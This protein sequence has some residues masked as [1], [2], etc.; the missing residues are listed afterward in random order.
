MSASVLNLLSGQ[1]L[2]SSSNNSQQNQSVDGPNLN[3]AGNSI[4]LDSSF[5]NGQNARTLSQFARQFSL[6]LSQQR[7]QF[8][9]PQSTEVGNDLPQFKKPIDVNEI[10][11]VVLEEMIERF[12]PELGNLMTSE[13]ASVNFSQNTQLSD[14]QIS[15]LQQQLQGLSATEVTEEA[16]PSLELSNIAAIIGK[17]DEQ[18]DSIMRRAGLIETDK[19]L[20]VD[21]QTNEPAVNTN[22]LL[23]D[24]KPQS[25]P[26]GLVEVI[27]PKP[28][29]NFDKPQLDVQTKP[30]PVANIERLPFEWVNNQLAVNSKTNEALD[31]ALKQVGFSEKEIAAIKIGELGLLLNK[32]SKLDL[33]AE[34]LSALKEVISIAKENLSKT[35]TA[36]NLQGVMGSVNI[37]QPKAIQSLFLPDNG[38][39]SRLEPGEPLYQPPSSA[40][41]NEL[42]AISGSANKLLANSEIQQG[43]NLK[44]NF[45]P[46]L[47]LR[48]QW[49]Y[50]QALSS[51]EILMDPPELGPLSIKVDN[52]KGETNI[53]FQV[54][55]GQ[56]KEMIESNLVKLKELLAE[57]GINLGD[58]QVEQNQQN[59]KDP[60]QSENSVVNNSSEHEETTDQTEHVIQTGLLDAYI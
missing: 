39:S 29:E 51:A 2:N 32:S 50:K 47:A 24:E 33:S 4:N 6:Q 3:A 20:K 11:P 25:R 31:L 12:G 42:N 60:S 1:T 5:Q 34:K 13:D 52:H 10:Q 59:D 53:V 8:Q 58:T 40:T 28:V 26:E 35:G 18:T 41:G 38:V 56:T 23:T 7:R 48:I 17:T 44:N 43:L 46:N 55:N 49:M 15:F 21:F 14:S 22:A 16:D 57:Q 19:G 9:Q 30:K 36:K 37:S 54:S 45:S 27:I